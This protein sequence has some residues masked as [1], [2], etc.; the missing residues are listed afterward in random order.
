MGSSLRH[1]QLGYVYSAAKK[2]NFRQPM[3]K[4]NKKQVRA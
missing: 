3:N 4:S 1:I 2:L